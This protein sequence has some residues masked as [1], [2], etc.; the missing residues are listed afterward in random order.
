MANGKAL[1]ESGDMSK[2]AVEFKNA[3]QI[4]PASLEAQY[5]LGLI[6][7]KQGGGGAAAAAFQKVA[8]ADPKHFEANRKAGQYSLM[9]GNADG[10]KRYARAL[11]TLAP[12]KA[13]GHTLMAAAI[14]LQSKLNDAEKE[15]RA[16]L[17][18]D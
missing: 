17:A 5:Y 12:D 7:E 13:D 11:I 9:A 10:A 2:A 6:A 8:D 14:L 1:Y 4:Q 15:A 18:I 3:L 16:A